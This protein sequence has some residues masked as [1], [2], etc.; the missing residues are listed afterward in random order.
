MISASNNLL[1]TDKVVEIMENIIASGGECKLVVTGNSMFPT[2]KHK[3]DSVV[4]VS[5][6]KRGIKKGEIVFIQRDSGEYILHRVY[7]LYDEYFIMN[8]DNQQWCEKVRFDQVIAVVKK[9][10]RKDK[11]ISCDNNLYKLYVST[12][13][14]LKNHRNKIYKIY[15]YIR[16]K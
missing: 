4:L 8:G 2:L 3:R 12:W 5:Q 10:V 13:I 16:K 15:S 6:S 1:E 9:I 14:I 7:K 11:E